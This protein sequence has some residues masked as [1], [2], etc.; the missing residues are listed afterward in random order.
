MARRSSTEER[1]TKTT[2]KKKAPPKAK[3]PTRVSRG[4]SVLSRDKSALSR[5][6]TSIQSLRAK[7]GGD[8]G[9]EIGLVLVIGLGA[10]LLMALLSHHPLDTRVDVWGVVEAD[11]PVRNWIGPLGAG[12][13]DLMVGLLGLTAFAMPV[14]LVLGAAALLGRRS[15]RPKALEAAGLLGVMLTLAMLVQ[16]IFP[17]VAFRGGMVTGGGWSGELMATVLVGWI[18]VAGTWVVGLTLLVICARLAFGVRVFSMGK[19]IA[20]KGGEAAQRGVGGARRGLGG[21][22]G[23]IGG[24]GGSIRNRWGDWRYERQLRREERAIEREE[25][26]DRLEQE[27]E[28]AEAARAEAE[29]AEAERQAELQEDEVGADST[30]TPP[31]TSHGPSRVR[32]PP[33]VVADSLRTAGSGTRRGPAEVPEPEPDPEPEAEPERVDELESLRETGSAA[34]AVASVTSA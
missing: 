3:G 5:V 2:K 15:R 33:V 29:R 7:R 8:L 11:R 18:S 1:S 4:S 23:W 14:L 24:L 19:A 9:T 13:S 6:R 25:Q 21:V 34:A 31:D 27:R 16:L 10:L 22:A 12:V 32:R 30:L 17:E 20:G 26:L 28:E